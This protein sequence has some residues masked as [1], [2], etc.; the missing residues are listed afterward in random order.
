MSWSS[1]TFLDHTFKAKIKNSSWR[2][3][4]KIKQKFIGYGGDGGGGGQG[5]SV[6]AL[7]SDDPSS[8]P[9]EVYSFIQ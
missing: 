2:G 6:L 8:N 9:A 4:V 5:V 3:W 7:Y 1:Q